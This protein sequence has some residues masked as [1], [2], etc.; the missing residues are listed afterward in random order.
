MAQYRV[1]QTYRSNDI[2]YVE[3]QI[4]DIDE[5]TAAW[6]LRDVPGCIVPV[7]KSSPVRRVME[8]APVD[9]M[10]SAVSKKRGE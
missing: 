4:L 6:M 7:D 8:S 5:N 1:T 10:V 2:G 9:R 3:G